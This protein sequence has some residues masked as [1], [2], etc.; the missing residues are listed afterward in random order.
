MT[1]LERPADDD[2]A[3]R[4]PRLRALDLDFAVRCNDTAH[5]RYLAHVLSPFE[6]DGE[7]DE[8]WS[9]VVSHDRTELSEIWVGDELSGRR[10]PGYLTLQH[11]FWR[12]NQETIRRSGARYLLLHASA[13][14]HD[15]RAVAFPAAMESGKTTLVA[16][17][18][19]C[20]FEYLTDEAVAIDPETLAV[21]PFPK[22][23]SIDPGSWGVLADLR[24]ELDEEAQAFERVQWQVPVDDIRPGARAAPA[25]IGHFV[26][27]RYDP[28]GPTELV[29]MRRSE[30]FQVAGENAFNLRAHGR[31]GF[32][33]LAEAVRRAECHR[34]AVSDL[35]QACELVTD[36]LTR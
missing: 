5:G 8:W 2:W 6:V 21:H 13:A 3:V 32:H 33:T 36:L 18:V 1:A 22:A 17:L 12:V 26:F 25:P 4:T 20:G 28:D 30:A 23:L 10:R 15:G 31:Q 29:P 27:P 24:P 7:P 14:V 35:D 19:R 9:V 16:G 34:L 11:L